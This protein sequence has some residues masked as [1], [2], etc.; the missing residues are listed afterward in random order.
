MDE[1]R[2]FKRFLARPVAFLYWPSEDENGRSMKM[3][4]DARRSLQRVIFAG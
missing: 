3:V 4:L 1:Q 2:L